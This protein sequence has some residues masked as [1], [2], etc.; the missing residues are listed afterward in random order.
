MPVCPGGY[1]KKRSLLASGYSCAHGLLN[2][3]DDIWVRAAS[4]D[5]AAHQLAVVVDRLCPALR[6]HC[7]GG[8]DLSR[9]A[10][11]ALKSILIQEGLLHRVQLLAF[12]QPFNRRDLGA[13]LHDGK[14]QTRIDSLAVHKNGARP[15]L[16]V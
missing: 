15:A 10:I 9:S 5:V 8:A 6:E 12:R 7:D 1:R 3:R 13:I 4:A 11:P 14:R 16:A 2:R